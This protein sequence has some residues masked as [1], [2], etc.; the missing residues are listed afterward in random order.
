MLS[1]NDKHSV[2]YYGAYYS[3]VTVTWISNSALVDYV[4]LNNALLLER[5]K[6]L[7]TTTELSFNTATYRYFKRKYKQYERR[8]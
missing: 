1:Y 8:N 7:N 3:K 5:Y 2:A 6:T 4:Q